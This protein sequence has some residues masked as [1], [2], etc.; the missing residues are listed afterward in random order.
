MGKY[1][2]DMILMGVSASITLILAQLLYHSMQKKHARWYYSMLVTAM[3]MLI[4]P[5]QS[6]LS[7][8]KMMR[9]RVP[10][11][12]VYSQASSVSQGSTGITIAG[13]IF[14]VWSIVAFLMLLS[15]AVKYIRTSRMLKT[16]SDITQNKAYIN[17]FSATKAAMGITHKIELR[18]S[19]YIRS[20]LLF[21]IIHPI[22]IIPKKDFTDD[23]LSMIMT[24]ELTHHKHKDL[25]IKLTAS[26]SICVQWFNPTAHILKRNI[27]TAC[28]LC[29]DESVLDILHLDDPKKYGRLILSVM[30]DSANK[31]FFCSTSMA[32][33][34]KGIR[35]RLIKI[36]EFKRH[37]VLFKTVSVML[38]LAAAVCSVTAF[39]VE[40]AK[41]MLPPETSEFISEIAEIPIS[42]DTPDITADTESGPQPIPNASG[43]VTP[44]PIPN[45]PGSY[46]PVKLNGDISYISA[47]NESAQ[48]AT[49]ADTYPMPSSD[50]AEYG[51]PETTEAPVTEPTAAPPVKTEPDEAYG[52]APK[53]AEPTKEMNVVITD[54]INFNGEHITQDNSKLVEVKTGENVNIE[55]KENVT[56][57]IKINDDGTYSVLRTETDDD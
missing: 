36:V 1:I 31:G 39:G 9:V 16:L 10:E 17:A 7:L 19:E 34:E 35:K 33:T 2:Y 5:I 13:M 54:S 12:I 24:H 47:D 41:E 32:S 52:E 38:V 14:L 45:A 26:F 6:V 21:G 57:Y 49:I 48:Q 3:L 29:C 15:V 51:E 23:E 8:P 20:P 11:N 56:A 50:P 43:D 22:I 30:E 25:L 37:G 27:I 40:Y 4:L 53:I 44:E 55:D 28:E 46:E 18:E 42:A